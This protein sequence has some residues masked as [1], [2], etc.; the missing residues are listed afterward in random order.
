MKGFTEAQPTDDRELVLTRIFDAPRLLVYKTWTQ[1]EHIAR[2]WG[3]KDF[4]NPVVELDV[5]P[6]GTWRIHMQAPDGTIYPGK[7]VYL[8]IDPPERLVMTDSWD[9]EDKPTQDLVW[10][11]TFDEIDNR[12][13]VTIRVRCAT[14]ADRDKIKEMGWY[15]GTSQSLDRLADCLRSM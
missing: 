4:T 8:E 14:V 10:T 6:G 9:Q 5:R 13:Q 12:T 2:W 1:P 15:E 7:G 11:V 3:P